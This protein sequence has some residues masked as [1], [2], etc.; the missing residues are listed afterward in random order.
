[1]V[2][3]TEDT[4]GLENVVKSTGFF[5]PFVPEASLSV[6]EEQSNT[7]KDAPDSLPAGRSPKPWVNS[8]DG[9]HLFLTF[10]YDLNQSQIK[11]VGKRYDYVWGSSQATKSPSEVSFWRQG[12][13]DAV[14]SWCAPAQRFPVTLWPAC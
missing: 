4:A 9:I 2:N 13:P 11:Q 10:D 12:N 1:M 6:E 8:T 5:M 3:T 14:I 7:S